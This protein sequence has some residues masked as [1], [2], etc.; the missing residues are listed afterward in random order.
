MSRFQHYKRIQMKDCI[1]QRNTFKDKRIYEAASDLW[2]DCRAS[3]TTPGSLKQIRIAFQHV[4][5]AGICNIIAN[6]INREYCYDY[7]CAT[8]KSG[9]RTLFIKLI[10]KLIDKGAIAAE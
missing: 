4:I 2:S 1:L 7:I 6:D 8:D 10:I 5:N 3:R 9:E